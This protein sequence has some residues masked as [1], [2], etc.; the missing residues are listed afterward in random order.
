MVKV[1]G[2]IVRLVLHRLECVGCGENVGPINEN[3]FKL[4]VLQSAWVV[5][6]WV[7]L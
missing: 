5:L 2:D 4:A 6:V 1:F 7:N 3:V